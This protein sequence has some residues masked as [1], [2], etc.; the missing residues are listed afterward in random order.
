M[1]VTN[2]ANYIVYVSVEM[3]TCPCD[4]RNCEGNDCCSDQCLGGCTGPGPNECFVCKNVEYNGRCMSECPYQT[5]M[6]SLDLLFP[7]FCTC[8]YIKSNHAVLIGIMFS[9]KIVLTSV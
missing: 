1:I 4:G 8:I 9:Y 2:D 7:F 5:Y 6:V 3:K